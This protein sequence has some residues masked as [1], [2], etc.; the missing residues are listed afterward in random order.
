MESGV[1]KSKGVLLHPTDM[2]WA[3]EA[4]VQEMLES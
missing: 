1:W 4:A 3:W 2:G